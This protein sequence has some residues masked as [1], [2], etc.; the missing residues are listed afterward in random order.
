MMPPAPLAMPSPSV[1]MLP[2]AGAAPRAVVFP[3]ARTWLGSVSLSPRGVA[4]LRAP[5]SR[6][7]NRDR[8]R[9]AQREAAHPATRRGRHAVC[10]SHAVPP[11]P[12]SPRIE[13]PAPA[14]QT[15]AAQQ[16]AAAVADLGRRAGWRRRAAILSGDDPLAGGADRGYVG[17][18][19]PAFTMRYPQVR[20]YKTWV[21]DDA[22]A[23]ALIDPHELVLERPLGVD[24]HVNLAPH[25]TFAGRVT[26]STFRGS[27]LLEP[28]AGDELHLFIE[29]WP[30]G[31][32]RRKPDR[33]CMRSALGHVYTVN[34]RGQK[35]AIAAR[36]FVI[37]LGDGLELEL[38]FTPPAPCA[39][40]VRVR[41][42]EG[43]LSI[44]LN[45][46][47]VVHVSAD[48]PHR[49]RAPRSTKKVR[50]TPVRRG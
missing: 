44:H 28:S 36:T 4:A 40:H 22:G 30:R 13:D 42:R 32:R 45:A 29:D 33:R 10:S 16:R 23:R 11:A 31:D 48:R 5:P 37:D 1:A 2:R 26:L 24:L 41:S 19:S 12:R 18:Q 7:D 49:P 21:V 38:A 43:A 27:L 47:N 46:A 8:R 14:R 50:S 9:R 20:P 3:A 35:T 39:H 17:R 34:A 6:S 25:P 15:R